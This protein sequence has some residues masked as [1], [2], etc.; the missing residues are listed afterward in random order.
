MK[1]LLTILALVCT[2]TTHAQTK[3]ELEFLNQLNT[4]RK[5]HKLGPAKYDTAVSRVAAY[6]CRYMAMCERQGH[7]VHH[8]ELP[9]DELFDIKGHNEM[10]FA[11]RAGMAPDKNIWGEIQIASFTRQ[12]GKSIAETAK[13]MVMAFDR[14]PGHKEAMLYEDY[15]KVTD[16][17]GISIVSIRTT[18]TYEEY[19]VNVDFGYTEK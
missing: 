2:S 9:H 17:V 18:E 5:Q 13:A 16:I 12:N 11:K 19:S 10:T 3:L 15:P 6:H 14:S 8:D 4:Y 7:S 1:R